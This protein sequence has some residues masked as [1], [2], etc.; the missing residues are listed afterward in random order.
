MNSDK[1][2]W[3]LIDNYLLGKS[4]NNG[5]FLYNDGVW[6]KDI[7]RLILDCLIG[8]DPTEEGIYALGNTEVLDRIKEISQEEALKIM[9]K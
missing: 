8:Y 9:G 6:E 5:C 3:Y 7:N 1:T 4:D 2:K